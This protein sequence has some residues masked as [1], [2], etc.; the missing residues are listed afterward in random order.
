MQSKEFL[1]FFKPARNPKETGTDFS[2]VPPEIITGIKGIF[3]EHK[4]G[5]DRV[6][7]LIERLGLLSKHIGP[8]FLSGS[9]A[10]E[11]HRQLRSCATIKNEGLFVAEVIKSLAPILDFMKMHPVEFEAAQ[12]RA[13]N[14][15]NNYIE[16]NRA[17]SYEKVDDSLI[18]HHSPSRTVGLTPA[19]YED[20]LRKLAII[21][22]DDIEIKQVE[23][24]SWLVA[25]AR[26]LFEKK[27]FT[28]ESIE[29][30]DTQGRDQ[31]AAYISRQ[32]FLDAFLDKK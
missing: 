25:R 24:V 22:R 10:E 20:A 14:E 28:V 19:L 27:G 30:K 4:K 2:D 32:N 6:N 15:R 3:R 9:T 26:P 29:E 17:V 8:E 18:L 7:A 5:E 23:A 13:G 31:A 21:A 11:I 16:L 1:H 12:A